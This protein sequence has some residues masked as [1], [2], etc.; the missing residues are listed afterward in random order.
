MRH[1]I[2]VDEV[3]AKWEN[4][5]LGSQQSWFP[6]HKIVQESSSYA[7]YWRLITVGLYSNP[8]NASPRQITESDYLRWQN[9]SLAK[10]ARWLASTSLTRFRVLFEPLYYL[11]KFKS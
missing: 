9:R 7:A 10:L 1:L 5:A 2:H 3:M 6:V 4:F 8:S 11:L